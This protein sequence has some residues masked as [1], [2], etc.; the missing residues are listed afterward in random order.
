M[1]WQSSWDYLSLGCFVC[2][3]FLKF[4]LWENSWKKN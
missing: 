4:L 2:Y 3:T 1:E